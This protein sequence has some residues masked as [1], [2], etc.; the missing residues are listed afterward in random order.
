MRIIYAFG[1]PLIFAVTP[2]KAAIHVVMSIDP[3]I[4]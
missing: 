3:Y 2:E 1:V 4:N